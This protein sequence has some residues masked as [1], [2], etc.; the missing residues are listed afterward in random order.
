MMAEIPTLGE[1]RRAGLEI[2]FDSTC[3]GE[4]R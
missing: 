4:L 3:A 1:C 2:G